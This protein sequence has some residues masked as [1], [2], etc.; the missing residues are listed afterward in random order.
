MPNVDPLAKA[1]QESLSK[2]VGDAVLLRRKALGM[3]AE[4]LAE[5]AR[6]LGYP[7]SRVAVTKIEGNK[8]AGKLDVAELLVLAVAL[9]IPPA[10]LLFPG[11]PDGTVD[12]VPGND[13]PVQTAR[14]WLCGDALLPV[15]LPA[16]M[17]AA[18]VTGNRNARINAGI[19]LVRAVNNR[20]AAVAQRDELTRKAFTE[21]TPAAVATNL[22][23]I[24]GDL[25][26]SMPALDDEIADAEA[27]LW[28][29]DDA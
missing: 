12:A 29:R 1:W 27:K 28:G 18:G 9:E 16:G 15:P 25:N 8:R 2:R 22:L 3:T 4:S 10:L 17:K 26:D 20:S 21:G 7:I 6:G 14:G 19:N 24:I 11:W 23:K 13:V 5:R